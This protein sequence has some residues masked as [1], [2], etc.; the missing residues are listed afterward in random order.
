MTQHELLPPSKHYSGLPA[1]LPSEVEIYRNG[2]I[3]K[4]PVV[5]LA[6]VAAHGNG[7]ATLSLLETRLKEETAKL[8]ADLVITYK[9]EV[10]QDETIGMYD[11]GFMMTDRIKR[12]HLYGIACVYSKVRLGVNFDKKGVI[13]YVNSGSIAEKYGLKEGFRI[14]AINGCFLDE[15]GYVL[16]TELSTKQPGDEIKLEYLDKNSEKQSVTIILE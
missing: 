14:L 11:S 16:E 13:E 4:K 8:G 10:T 15:S 3:P 9:Y 5:R 6:A 7:Y 2:E 12:P 1:K